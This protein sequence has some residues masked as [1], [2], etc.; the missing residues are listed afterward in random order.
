M[1]EKQPTPFYPIRQSSNG[2]FD[3]I[4]LRC[5]ATIANAKDVAALRT[6]DKNHVCDPDSPILLGTLRTR[7]RPKK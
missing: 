6:H 1:P 2:A 4:C 7:S 3:S 5:F